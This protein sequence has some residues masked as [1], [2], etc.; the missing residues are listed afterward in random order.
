MSTYDK[1]WVSRCSIRIWD[2]KLIGIILQLLNHYFPTLD[3][4][5]SFSL[6]LWS[7]LLFNFS[8]WICETAGAGGGDPGWYLGKQQSRIHFLQNMEIPGAVFGRGGSLC[9]AKR[10]TTKRQ[11]SA[12]NILNFSKEPQLLQHTIVVP[13]SHKRA[14]KLV[15]FTLPG[16]NA[17]PS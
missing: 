12:M 8:R 17:N 5:G 10:T 6:S 15:L 3:L 1:S 9:K 7:F 11:N 14:R 4:F 2:C 13:E 16:D